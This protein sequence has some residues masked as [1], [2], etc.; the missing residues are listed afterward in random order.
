MSFK[1]LCFATAVTVCFYLPALA[2]SIMVQDPYA[3]A[4]GKSASSAAAFMVVMNHGDA[5][6]RLVGVT[7]D[8]AKKVELHT[9]SEEANGV[10]TMRHL[11]EGAVIPAGGMHALERGGDHVMFMGLVAP[12]TQGDEILVT[13]MFENAGAV[14]VTV[15]VDLK[16]TA[17]KHKMKHADN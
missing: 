13:L 8:A 1:A 16:R 5:D 10:M 6:D 11:A 2:G 14:A 15:P 12:M 7:S 17:K 4:S 9:H 3:R